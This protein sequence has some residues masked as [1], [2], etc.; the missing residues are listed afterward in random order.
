MILFYFYINTIS[1]PLE[2]KEQDFG[3]LSRF[4]NNLL[5]KKLKD[6]FSN[7]RILYENII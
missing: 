5:Y 4:G 3:I 6:S 1:H 2:V 7:D